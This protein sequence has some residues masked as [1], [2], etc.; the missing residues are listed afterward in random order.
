MCTASK[1]LCLSI[2]YSAESLSSPVQ[3]YT[4]IA[5]HVAIKLLL[6]GYS[7]CLHYITVKSK[8]ENISG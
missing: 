2:S 3:C 8:D 7:A 4:F 1:V 6:E 5:I